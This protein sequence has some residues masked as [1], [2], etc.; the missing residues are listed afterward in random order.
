MLE[1]QLEAA[2]GELYEWAA[3]RY[4]GAVHTLLSRGYGGRTFADLQTCLGA[5]A[6]AFCAHKIGYYDSGFSKRAHAAIGEPAG[7]G[8]SGIRASLLIAMVGM[9]GQPIRLGNLYVPHGLLLGNVQPDEMDLRRAERRPRPSLRIYTPCDGAFIQ[10]AEMTG[11]NL[12]IPGSTIVVWPGKD[13]AGA[14]QGT[15]AIRTSDRMVN[16]RRNS[17][18]FLLAHVRSP[19]DDRIRFGDDAS[20]C[21]GRKLYARVIPASLTLQIGPKASRVHSRRDAARAARVD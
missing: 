12:R 21:D 20:Y 7:F 13:G 11:L 14:A 3:A 17:K 2:F 16:T 5:H 4:P 9:P 1:L 6:R 19:S 8:S 15:K 10:S 18:P